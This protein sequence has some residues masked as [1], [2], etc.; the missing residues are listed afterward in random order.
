[1]HAYQKLS[2][3]IPIPTA[4][5]MPNRHPA[6]SIII[7]SF[8]T[9]ELTLSCIRSI[10]RETTEY[11]YEII[12]IDNNSSDGSAAAI[13]ETFPHLL[14]IETGANLGF[15]GANN[16]AAKSAQG[17][18]L[19]LLNPDTLVLNGAV[20]A[21]MKFADST[22]HAQLWGGRAFFPDKSINAS[23]WNDM[24]LWSSLCRA[25][26]L[27][28]IFPKSKL[29][30]PESIHLWSSLDRERNV[31]IVVGCFLLIEKSTWDR[32]GGFNTA[33]FL[34]GD[35][36][37]LCLRARKLGAR[38]RITPTAAIIHYG[39]RSEPSSEDKLIKV[40]KGRITVMKAHWCPLAAHV[41]RWLLLVTVG[42]RVVGSL[43]FWPPSHPGAGLDG[44]SD[45]WPAVFRRRKEWSGGWLPA[46]SND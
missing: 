25:V 32:L 14:L 34:Y 41:G 23:C 31:D 4:K 19:L 43:F 37:D 45:V 38:P 13:R 22:P 46:A 44:R 26:G 39:G 18:R 10:I 30:N 7:V 24:T 28:W 35:E 15:A 29:F 1:M 21:L 16:V 36:V 2:G 11:S 5:L 20:D 8:N 40:F 33:F 12:V 27:T 3:H 17:S 6:V 42:L 9:K